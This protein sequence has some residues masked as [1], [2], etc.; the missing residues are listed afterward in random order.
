[1]A[2][3][4]VFRSPLAFFLFAS[5]TFVTALLVLEETGLQGLAYLHSRRAQL[6][7][8]LIALAPTAWLTSLVLMLGDFESYRSAWPPTRR[9]RMAVL[10]CLG[11]LV[12]LL[13]LPL[14]AQLVIQREDPRLSTLLAPLVS[15]FA[16]RLIGMSVLGVSVAALQ[17]SALVGIHLQFL[18]RL[19]KYQQ[20]AE[21]PGPESLDED[22]RWYLLHQ[23]QMRRFL[24]AAATV[25][26]I[27]MLGVGALRNVLN[28]VL[29]A[30]AEP[31]PIEPVMSYGL[32]Y[33]GLIA[34]LYVPAHRTQ[35]QVGQALA[36]RLVWQTLGAHPTWKQ[37]LE[38]QQAIRD[39]LGLRDSAIQELQQG[40]A[41]LAPFLAS[42]SSLALGAGG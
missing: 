23:A 37:R 14:L 9:G 36:E 30:S 31:F 8:M 22:V 33:T 21:H 20:L 34:S 28:E 35:K 39:H 29:P 10:L 42:L 27:S 15:G 40:L 13:A 26:G 3:A 6:W 17:A 19:P 12:F 16:A 5:L 24:R 41:V 7:H 32:Y 4:L 18:G 2:F 25:L 38:E 11:P 1:M